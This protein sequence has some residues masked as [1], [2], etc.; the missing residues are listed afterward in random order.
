[1]ALIEIN[2]IAAY[3]LSASECLFSDPTNGIFFVIS[4]YNFGCKS[5]FIQVLL[6][7]CG[8]EVCYIEEVEHVIVEGTSSTS[9][10]R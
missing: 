3:I 8:C 2:L 7:A 9:G 6:N 1:M 5:N 4:N 10:G